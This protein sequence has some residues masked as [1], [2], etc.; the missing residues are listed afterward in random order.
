MTS[1][2]LIFNHIFGCC[3]SQSFADYFIHRFFITLAR[4]R[5]ADK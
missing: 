1:D 2:C 4:Y 3:G 5:I